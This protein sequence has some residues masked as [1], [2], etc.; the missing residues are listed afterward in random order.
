MRSR[1]SSKP[2]L[3]LGSVSAIAGP[4]GAIVCL[5]TLPENRDCGSWAAAILVD[6]I[7]VGACFL[8]VKLFAVGTC[9]IRDEDDV[10]LFTMGRRVAGSTTTAD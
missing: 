2:K 9:E 1:K 5:L 6:F 4:T 10:G 7:V 3:T 8:L